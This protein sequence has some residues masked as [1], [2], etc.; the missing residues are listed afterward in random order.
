MPEVTNERLVIQVLTNQRPVLSILTNKRPVLLILSNKML[1]LPVVLCLT[2]PVHQD[3]HHRG[4]GHLE[5]GQGCEDGLKK[6]FVKSL[7]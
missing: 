3:D 5:T 4:G 2:Q 6:I 7:I 1:V